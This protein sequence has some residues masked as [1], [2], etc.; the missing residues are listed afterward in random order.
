M[1]QAPTSNERTA[2]GMK[3]NVKAE[4][5]ATPTH[6]ATAYTDPVTEVEADEAFFATVAPAPE[7]GVDATRVS[8][9]YRMG[10][11]AYL[12]SP[13][14]AGIVL[15]ILW[16]DTWA[17]ALIGWF[18]ALLAVTT[19]RVLAHAAYLRAGA[20]PPRRWERRFAIG[21]FA[22][23]AAWAAVPA[24]F[25]ASEDPLLLMAAV[26]VVGGSIIAAAGLYA[27]SVL[28]LYAYV[29]PPLLALI[30]QLAVQPDVAFRYLALVIGL[31]GVVIVRIHREMN[32][33][34]LDTLR[35]RQEN[36]V[37]RNRAQES[38]IR[39]RAAIES[40]PEGIAIFDD[41]A[42]LVTCNDAFAQRYGGGRAR[43]A[44]AGAAYGDLCA[45]AFEVEEPP[46]EFAAR[47]N[48]WIA[49]RLEDLRTDRAAQ[50]QFR[51]RDGRSSPRS[52]PSEPPRPRSGCR[53][54]PG[55]ISTPPS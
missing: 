44:L 22:S 55:A 23:G 32:H 21:A 12:V 43:D 30:G 3:N 18:G 36:E 42:S 45:A 35:A 7:A 49:A 29:V 52:P 53:V 2:P 24:L 10:R 46:P 51:A 8:M 34:L 31:F 13:V 39:M 47:R 40:F 6:G 37:L 11:A 26:F 14:Y 17:D 25:F 9:L 50:R 33:S 20:A 28:S 4:V 54:R 15:M 41:G 48:E 5:N 19:A 1:G 27:A 38:E 16:R